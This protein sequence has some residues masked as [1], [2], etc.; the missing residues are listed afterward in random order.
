MAL[1]EEGQYELDSG[2]PDVARRVF[3]ELI[4]RYPDSEEAL[5]AQSYLARLYR[6]RAGAA[7][8]PLP[9][10]SGTDARRRAPDYRLSAPQ[11]RPRRPP[12]PR[13]AQDHKLQNLLLRS[14]GDR[15]F[16]PPNSAELGAKAR[17]ALRR[18]ARWLLRRK[19][20]MI[21]VVGH[22]DEAISR[23]GNKVLSLRR[24]EAVRRRLV[25][26]GVDKA[27]VQIDGRGRAERL[28]ICNGPACA[29]Q[30]R[31]VETRVMRSVSGSSQQRQS[32]WSVKRR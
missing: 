3:E 6:E 13:F 31:R 15:V 22:A 16:F 8:Q 10:T 11:R 4:S 26:E 20:L 5:K 12:P 7:S 28:A 1:F 21:Q 25:E 29:A 19:I 30:N 24:A 23:D 9:R 17:L 18:Q 32:S 2:Q 27:R 14:V